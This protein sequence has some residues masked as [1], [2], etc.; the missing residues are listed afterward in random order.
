[1]GGDERG[2]LGIMS[3][4]TGEVNGLVGSSCGGGGCWSAIAG[5][6]DGMGGGRR[7][8][9]VR[10]CE[11]ASLG[12]FGLTVSLFL[13]VSLQVATGPKR[14]EWTHQANQARPSL[15]HAIL[16]RLISPVGSSKPRYTFFF[17]FFCELYFFSLKWTF[18]FNGN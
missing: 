14:A 1:M 3:F 5:D 12:C 9:E 15:A 11:R 18:R 4:K 6:D 10:W 2:Y 7:L 16:A 8:A 17:P 13:S